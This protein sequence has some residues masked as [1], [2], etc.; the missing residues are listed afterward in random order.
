MPSHEDPFAHSDNLPMY[1]FGSLVG[2][3]LLIGVML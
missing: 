2:L 1:A 3:A